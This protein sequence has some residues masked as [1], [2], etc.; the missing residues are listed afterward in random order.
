MQIYL[1]MSWICIFSSICLYLCRYYLNVLN[2]FIIKCISISKLKWFCTIMYHRHLGFFCICVFHNGLQAKGSQYA[3]PCNILFLKIDMFWCLNVP[4]HGHV[5]MVWFKVCLDLVSARILWQ[6]V[7]CP[8]EI[9]WHTD[10]SSFTV[11]CV[12]YWIASDVTNL[13]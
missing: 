12:E 3:H 7:C 2:G 13:C 1:I 6:C 10:R 11:N 4:I 9:R 8:N 5:W